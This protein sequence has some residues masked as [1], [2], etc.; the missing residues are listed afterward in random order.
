MLRMSPR[1]VYHLVS[2][3]DI[4]FR[5]ARGRL[6]FER[7]RIEAW[8]AASA[9]GPLMDDL[10]PV[11]QIIA[12][13]HDPLLEWAVRNSGSGLALACQGSS[14]GLARLAARQA[15]AALIHLP[16]PQGSG[17]NTQAIRDA[18]GGLPVVSLHWA[19][20]EQGLVLAP[21]NPLKINSL[22]DLVRRRVRVVRRQSGAGSNH[23]FVR[24]LRQ[25]GFGIEGLRVI[26]PLALNETEVAEAVLDGYADA[27]LAIRAVAQ[28]HG[29]HFLPL[30]E[31][32]VEL[33]A[34]RR[35]VFEPPLQALLEITRSRRFARQAKSLGG[36]G[37]TGLGAVRY[38]G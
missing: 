25:A 36:Y 8:L 21:G 2:R 34:W 3:G 20:R 5:R 19:V 35:S 17:F 38:N 4:P 12:G 23:L 28:R 11:D 1:T 22:R 24:L 32:S 7:H 10:G 18:L 16:D 9:Q 14:D 26:E 30:A 13:S 15:C 6:L 37:L 27:G 29:L 33:V 31:E